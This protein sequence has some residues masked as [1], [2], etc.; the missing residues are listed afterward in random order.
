VSALACAALLGAGN[1]AVFKLVSQYF[2][3]E[4]GT[5]T[6][7]AGAMAGLGGFFPPLLRGV[8]RERRGIIW[9]G[10]VLLALTSIALGI[11]NGRAFLRPAGA[12]S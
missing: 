2:P 8:L 11:V 6:G 3:A 4:T 1:G 9:P 5:V 7:L 10:F 12:Q